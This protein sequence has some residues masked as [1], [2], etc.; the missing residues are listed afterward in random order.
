MTTDF[1]LIVENKPG[2]LAD[3]AQALGRVGENIE[4]ICCFVSQAIAMVHVAVEHAGAARRELE[5]IGLKV[6][7]AREV[8]LVGLDDHPGAAGD[9][10]RRLGDAGINIDMAYLATHTRLVVSADD[11]EKVRHVIG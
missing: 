8:A 2:A 7:E 9:V 6:Y 10:L 3:V 4:G 11:L 5:A 1:T